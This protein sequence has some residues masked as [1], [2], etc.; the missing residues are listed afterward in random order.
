MHD[1]IKELAEQYVSTVQHSMSPSVIGQMKSRPETLWRNVMKDLM[2][3]LG[4]YIGE[5]KAWVDSFVETATFTTYISLSIYSFS[6]EELEQFV[7][8]AIAIA[9]VARRRGEDL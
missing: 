5:K 8:G 1:Q 4:M 2:M 6:K 7:A 9:W 3:D